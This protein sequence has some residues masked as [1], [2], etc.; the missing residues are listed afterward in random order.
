MITSGATT[1]RVLVQ[2]NIIPIVC[3]LLVIGAVEVSEK[4]WDYIHFDE[5]GFSITALG[6][7]TTAFS[8]FLVFRVNEAYSRWWEARILWGGIVN[9]SRTFAR[10]VTTLLGSEAQDKE[11]LVYRHLAY[12]NALR[13]SLRREDEWDSLAPYLD[14][15]ELTELKASANKATQLVQTQGKALAELRERGH[16]DEFGHLMLDN[17]LSELYNLQ[18]GCERIKNTVFPDRVAYFTKLIA[19]LMAGLIPVCVLEADNVYDLLDF[20]LIPLIMLIFIVTERLGAELKNPFENMANDTPMTA[21][22]R[23]IEIDLRQQLGETD[24]PAPLAARRW[25]THVA[26]YPNSSMPIRYD[27]LPTS[28]YSLIAANVI[29]LLGVIFLGWDVFSIVFVYWTE[30][31]VLGA[32]NLLKMLTCAPDE[33]V[34]LAQEHSSDKMEEDTQKLLDKFQGKSGSLSKAHHAA[35]LFFMPFFTVHYGIFCLVHGVFVFAL[36]SGEGPFGGNGAPGPE[37]DPFDMK[38]SF[39]SAIAGNHLWWAILALAGSHLYSFFANYLGK[40]EYRQTV[41]PQLMI[42]PYGRIVVLH[43]ALLFGAFLIMALGSPLLLL[44]ILIV[45]KTGLDLKL[46]LREHQSGG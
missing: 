40:G 8:I 22:C 6:L 26:G 33:E 14:T 2:K 24:V 43:V 4:F 13:M 11:R 16:L 35:K 39:L 46:H 9:Y 18:G 42:Q 19:W 44:L 38:G 45:G 30:N 21:L 20:I 41:L 25:D 10:Q 7:L 23:T 28:A 17:T 12:I 5:P 27:R 29:P 31:V 15:A 37:F 32:I 36:L 34:I 1:I 3:V